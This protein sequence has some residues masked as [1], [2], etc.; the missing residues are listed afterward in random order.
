MQHRMQGGDLLDR[1]G[2]LAEPGWAKS[3]VRRYDRSAVRA[4]KW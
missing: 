4:G 2:R 3:E 1:A